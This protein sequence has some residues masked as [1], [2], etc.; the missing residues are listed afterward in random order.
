MTREEFHKLARMDAEE[1]QFVLGVV[2]ANR[3]RLLGETVKLADQLA[4]CVEDI[5]LLREHIRT[6]RRER[7]LVML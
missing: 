6:R 5:D 1:L 3:A 2:E 4:E 7:Q